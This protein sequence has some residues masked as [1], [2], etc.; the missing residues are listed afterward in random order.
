MAQM[1][2]RILLGTM[3]LAAVGYAGT[4]QF[5]ASAARSITLTSADK[6]AVDMISDYFN[7]HRNLQGEFTQIGPR[8]HVST[9]VFFI[10]KP[11][12]LRFEYAPPNPFIIVSDGTW[13]T[14]KNKKRNRADQY[15]LSQTPLDLMLA[16]RVNL[17]KDAKIISV[18]QTGSLSRI[19]LESKST[20]TSGQLTIVFDTEK[21]QLQQWVVIDG[22]GLRTTVTLDKIVTGVAAKAHL[23]KVKIPRKEPGMDR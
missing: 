7:K 4:A 3:F 19:T 10:S 23:F 18:G 20:L 16:K 6:S 1:L 8:G 14:V 9:G 17:R 15:P 21:Q 12:R 22:K 5:T 13:V 2:K 11:G